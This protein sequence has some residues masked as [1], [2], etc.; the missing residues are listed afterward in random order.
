MPRTKH[1]SKDIEMALQY[2]EEQGWQISKTTGSS[3]CWGYMRCPENSK[4]CW[5]GMHCQTSIWSTPRS[6]GN[7]AKAI[8][9]IVDK[10]QFL[11]DSDE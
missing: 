4:D 2:A 5:N 6:T 8:K 10:C 7:H 3:H 11:G 1:P 9:R